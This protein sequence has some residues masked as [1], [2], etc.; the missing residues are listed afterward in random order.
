MSERNIVPTPDMRSLT[1]KRRE[2]FIKTVKP[3]AA[4]ARQHY[5]IV[6]QL[7]D[8]D[9][10]EQDVD[11]RLSEAYILDP[12][13]NI[14]PADIMEE[15]ANIQAER[16]RLGSMAGR[17]EAH[18]NWREA[19]ND[20]IIAT[21]G[22]RKELAA[23]S[24]RVDVRTRQQIPNSRPNIAQP[25]PYSPT[26]QH[27]DLGELPIYRN[28]PTLLPA[29]ERAVRH[30]AIIASPDDRSFQQIALTIADSL[31]P[32]HLSYGKPKS[33][34][35]AFRDPHAVAS[36]IIQVTQL[37][38]LYRQGALREPTL[39]ELGTPT[40]A[41]RKHVLDLLRFA[42]AQTLSSEL[43]NPDIS[44]RNLKRSYSR[45]SRRMRFVATWIGD[46]GKEMFG[47]AIAELTDAEAAFLVSRFSQALTQ[48]FG[49]PVPTILSEEKYAEGMK[50]AAF[51]SAR[52]VDPYLN[53]LLCGLADRMEDGDIDEDRLLEQISSLDYAAYVVKR[54]AAK[55]DEQGR[56]TLKL[57]LS[58]SS[59]R[60]FYRVF[61]WL[62]KNT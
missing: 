26:R 28:T 43:Q 36:G 20:I 58:Q 39:A 30:A 45:L 12:D 38:S 34:P 59:D 56:E 5:I 8:L 57:L 54:I 60:R 40:E 24:M 21:N 48:D 50:N 13:Q 2:S 44:E 41:Q 15:R 51:G 32:R 29:L 53:D 17:R 18:T 10:R 25:E 47:R 1:P 11:E 35:R 31:L 49:F 14:P 55:A 19:T 46:H 61:R 33:I 4:K 27:T 16:R 3:I 52:F 6:R 42:L 22:L 7:N 62:L 37:I 9:R 23:D